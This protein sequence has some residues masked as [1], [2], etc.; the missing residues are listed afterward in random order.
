MSS[1]IDPLWDPPSREAPELQRQA[2]RLMMKLLMRIRS[3]A[4]EVLSTP[5]LC[6]GERVMDAALAASLN[7]KIDPS[8]RTAALTLL[9]RRMKSVDPKTRNRIFLPRQE[10][11]SVLSSTFGM[12]LGDL[13]Q[14]EE[15]LE[16]YILSERPGNVL[17]HPSSA[18]SE[19]ALRRLGLF[20][21]LLVTRHGQI[22]R[23]VIGHAA[24]SL[25]RPVQIYG[26]WAWID[27]EI[28]DSPN[29]TVQIRRLFMDPTTLAAWLMAANSAA[30]LAAP[31]E[32]SKPGVANQF[33][34]RSADRGFA[35]LITHMRKSEKVPRIDSLKRLC[36]CQNQRLHVSAMPLIATYA[37]GDIVSSSLESSTWLRLIGA[38]SAAKWQPVEVRDVSPT[39]PREVPDVETDVAEQIIAG[40]LEEE[41][42][43]AELRALMQASR[44]Q[45][46][47]LFD[48]QLAKMRKSMPDAA[49]AVL[50][51]SW[52][53][54]LAV[55]RKSKGKQLADGS[56]HHYRGLLVNRLIAAL[57][58]SLD[59][60]DADEL[61]EAYE[62]V[63]VSRK[64]P[65][66]ASRI[67]TSL[68][69]FDRYVRLHHLPELPK[70]ALPG[71]EGGGYAISAR[72]ISPTEYQH[73]LDLIGDGT[74]V[75]K[76][77]LL[78]RRV[79]AFWILAFRFGLRRA[80]ILGLQ[81]RDVDQI[82]VRVRVNSVRALKTS[83]AFRLL[84]L[85]VLPTDEIDAVLSLGFGR[86][87]SDCLFF[88]EPLPHRK[89]LDAHPVILRINDLLERI[90]GDGR[91]HPHNLRHSTSTLLPLGVLGPDLGLTDHPYAEPWMLEAT[92]FAQGVDK[93]ISG[94]LHR[95]SARG[96]ALGMM[97]GHGDEATTYEHYVHSLDLLLFFACCSGRFDPV[98]VSPGEH[99]YSK[100]SET[101]Q[102][103]A[104]L[105]YKPTSR[106]STSDAASLLEQIAERHPDRFAM[107]DS[108]AAPSSPS[109]P[110]ASDPGMITLQGLLSIEVAKDWRG[111][112]ATQAQRDTVTALLPRIN[113]ARLK[114]TD[115]L[116]RCLLSW[117]KAQL[118]DDDWASMN[119]VEAL[120]F[121]ALASD[122]PIEA[123]WVR[124]KGRKT[125]KMALEQDSDLS[126]VCGAG[127]GK[128][129]VRLQDPRAKRPSSR[130][131]KTALARSWSQSTISWVVHAVLYALTERRA[132][133]KGDIAHP[134][135]GTCEP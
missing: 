83:N 112:P 116:E 29:G 1:L 124:S 11:R 14:F 63:I 51:V 48:A 114:D 82:W 58:S 49:T 9:Q 81:V 74:M 66:Q 43:I 122:L 80:E 67:R 127:I 115:L 18:T 70:V 34:R 92:A 126:R 133:A 131:K 17:R 102:L 62:E 118:N 73:G 7:P 40:D 90:T 101:A 75:F 106:V 95:R 46:A 107:W 105:G 10:H 117:A 57:P 42:L 123:L 25:N 6:D 68:A 109:A 93:A 85:H 37:R 3:R 54:Y 13:E 59:S 135:S 86:N 12:D 69:D 23:A 71:F 24:G 96:A 45:W 44:A 119:A 52:L 77:E 94:Q 60:V 41:G 79:R 134:A 20:L 88:N 26:K 61:A 50:A 27:I 19:E 104:M 98:K 31:P 99:T 38:T 35:A 84:P 111:W 128:V 55:D 91:L 120:E 39:L 108:V 53:R 22:S 30:A 36:A 32:G 121:Y 2:H 87:P 8:L 15:V 47:D 21:A 97:M 125:L 78:G 72:I 76:D 132:T 129:W 103:L 5:A 64:S 100:R 89:D 130:K 4:P 33:F 113:A 110:I 56:L 28:A 65:Q 16:E